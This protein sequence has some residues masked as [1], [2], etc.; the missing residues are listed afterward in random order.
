MCFPSKS[1]KDNFTD[2]GAKTKPQTQ[3]GTKNTN[4]TSTKDDKPQPSTTT[5]PPPAPVA[6]STV[7][8]SATMSAPR[9]AIITYSMYGHIDKLATAIKAGVENAG[10]KADLLQVPETLTPEIL[11]LMGAPPKPS[12]KNITTEDLIKYDAYLL[13][14]PTRFGNMPGQWKAFW[15]ATGGL[16]AKGSLAGKYAGVFVSTGSHG[17]GQEATVMNTLSTLTHHGIIFVPFGYSH[18]FGDI[19][20]LNEVHAGSPWGA[21]TFAGADGSRQP[22]KLELTI[23]EKQGKA[24]WDTVSKVKF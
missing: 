20:N 2:G 3:N 10:G 24:F 11:T 22:S 8:A 13:G 7:P 4:G 14:I 18:A 19:T 15:D 6:A 1:Q 23:A 12:T 5:Q 16:W 9:V 17:G 21:G